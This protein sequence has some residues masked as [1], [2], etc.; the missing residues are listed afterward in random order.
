MT[1]FILVFIAY[2]LFVVYGIPAIMG[3]KPFY[4]RKD[5]KIAQVR[6]EFRAKYLP[7]VDK[8]ITA[9]P[10]DLYADSLMQQLEK[11]WDDEHP[12]P[13]K[14]IDRLKAEL[15]RVNKLYHMYADRALDSSRI[16]AIPFKATDSFSEPPE[17][18]SE[19]WSSYRDEKT[20]YYDSLSQYGILGNRV[21]GSEARLKEELD[22]LKGMKDIQ[23]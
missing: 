22:K 3:R 5:D 11:Q 10:S 14:E 17:Y 21:Y 19:F 7:P 18:D 13:Q 1:F 2:T 20:S 4:K 6:E 12:D 9:L 23:W 15:A 8:A 16:K